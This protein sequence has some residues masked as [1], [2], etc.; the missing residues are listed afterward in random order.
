MAEITA[1][2]TVRQTELAAVL[3]ISARHIRRLTES[4]LLHKTDGLYVLAEAVQAYVQSVKGKPDNEDDAETERKRRKAEAELKESKAVIERLK[5]DELKGKMHR[6]E[7]VKALM[8]DMVFAIRSALLALPGRLA[9]DTAA[10]G[11]P[12][13][14]SAIIRREVNQTMRELAAYRYDPQKFEERIRERMQWELEDEQE[15][16]Q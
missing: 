1:A 5:A 12:A 2:T 10:A 16:E 13:E 7:D 15:N 11:T 6:Q 3:G 9:V 4:G 8:D 14:S